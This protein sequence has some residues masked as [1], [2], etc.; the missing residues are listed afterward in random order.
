MVP[1][2]GEVYPDN[3]MEKM[4]RFIY[5]IGKILVLVIWYMIVLQFI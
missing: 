4:E 3:L 5:W 2:H 1:V